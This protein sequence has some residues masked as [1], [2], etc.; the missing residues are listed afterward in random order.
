[1]SS[2]RNFKIS[3]NANTMKGYVGLNSEDHKLPSEV[4]GYI[5]ENYQ[6]TKD[7]SIHSFKDSWNVDVVKSL[8][9]TSIGFT[10]AQ[11]LE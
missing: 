9:N 11:N 1:M 4:R 3:E 10:T 7:E 8:P 6:F 5:P 2:F